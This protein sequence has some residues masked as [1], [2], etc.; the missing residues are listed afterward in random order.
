[1]TDDYQID[2]IISLEDVHYRP[3]CPAEKELGILG[4]VAGKNILELACGGAQNSIALSKWGAHTTAV[5]FSNRQL[6]K[7]KKLVKQ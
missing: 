2:T 1:M 5:D 4:D 3:V 7:A 6:S